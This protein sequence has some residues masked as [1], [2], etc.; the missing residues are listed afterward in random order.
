ML[1]HGTT[2]ARTVGISPSLRAVTGGVADRGLIPGDGTD[3]HGGP[4]RLVFALASI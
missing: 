2:T 4:V 1:V 3:R